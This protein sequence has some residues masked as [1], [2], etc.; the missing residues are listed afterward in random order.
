M[1]ADAVALAEVLQLL[2]FERET[3]QKAC[4]KLGASNGSS[5]T[6]PPL[7]HALDTSQSTLPM[8][9]ISLQA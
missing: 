2:E 1:Y 9:G 3:W 6:V 5:A 8:P 7:S 4:E